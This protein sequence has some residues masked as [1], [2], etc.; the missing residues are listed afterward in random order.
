M[1]YLHAILFEGSPKMK[2]W[3]FSAQEVHRINDWERVSGRDREECFHVG[4][5]SSISPLREGL[6]FSFPPSYEGDVVT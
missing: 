1:Y 5:L 4:G 3:E 6:V 2:N